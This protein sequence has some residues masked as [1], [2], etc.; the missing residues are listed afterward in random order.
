MTPFDP[1]LPIIAD[2]AK[3]KTCHV[4]HCWQAMREMGKSFHIGAFANF[5]GLETHHID[6]ILTALEAH[7]ALPEKRATATSK[8]SRLALDWQLPDD[9]AGWATSFK[10]WSPD[11]VLAEAAMFADYWH[12][13]AG[14]AAVKLDW[15]KTW[16]N[17]V[18][19]SRRQN[20]DYTPFKKSN[21]RERLEAQ[22]KTELMLGRTYEADQIRRQL[23]KMDN[24]IPFNRTDSLF[25][26]KAA[27]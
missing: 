17:W 20:G 19:N 6:R 3:V 8:G 22:L 7:D 12:S 18:R 21:P 15:E 1:R 9:W 2:E 11:E 24:V 10:R 14:A 5:T 23:S 4:Y 16:H 13:K 26:L 27:N 25:E